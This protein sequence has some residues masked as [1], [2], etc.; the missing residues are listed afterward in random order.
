MQATLWVASYTVTG[1]QSPHFQQSSL[2]EGRAATASLISE[3]ITWRW[4]FLGARWYSTFRLRPEQTTADKLINCAHCAKHQV[5]HTHLGEIQQGLACST[6]GKPPT[7]LL[8]EA[9]LLAHS[10]EARV[11]SESKVY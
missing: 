11:D 8:V 2:T 7:S 5:T 1:T 6:S 3:S 4:M 10:T 9:V